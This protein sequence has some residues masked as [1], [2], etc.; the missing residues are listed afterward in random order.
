MNQ[1]E[2]YILR[3]LLSAVAMVLSV[4][5]VLG[6][7]SLFI[8]EQDEIGTGSYGALQAL[9]YSVL[10]L[11]TIALQALPAAVLV[12]AMLGIGV[13]ARSNELTVMRCSGMSKLRLV[14]A[15][16]TGGALLAVVALLVGE[17]I[18]PA[19]EQMA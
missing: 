16:L 10:N 1:L 18:S 4:L 11:P 5:L 15:A 3:T 8:G 17:Y 6:A 7:L 12:G 2:R 14:R 9:T 13:L 19:L